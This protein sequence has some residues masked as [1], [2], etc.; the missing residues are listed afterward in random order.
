MTTQ[1]GKYK[2]SM[3]VH[4]LVNM[5]VAHFTLVRLRNFWIICIIND[6]DLKDLNVFIK[7]HK[8]EK[9]SY[10]AIII[11][12]YKFWPASMWNKLYSNGV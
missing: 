11:N 2:I 12:K 5:Y 8:Y 9:M 10:N 4:T 7:F 6:E 1:Q 3:Y